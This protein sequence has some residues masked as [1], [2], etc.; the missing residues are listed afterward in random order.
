MRYY[1]PLAGGC[2]ECLSKGSRHC[3]YRLYR[4]RKDKDMVDK[5]AALALNVIAYV[6]LS[7]HTAKVVHNEQRRENACLRDEEDKDSYLAFMHFAM[8][9]QEKLMANI[10]KYSKEGE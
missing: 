6:M 4:E 9:A 7:E 10:T 2:W 1:E 8:P 3:K 5:D